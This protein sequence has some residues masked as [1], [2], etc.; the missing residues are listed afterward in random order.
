MTD[1]LFKNCLWNGDASIGA[2][3][4][5]L[6]AYTEILSLMAILLD[7]PSLLCA[8]LR[9]RVSGLAFVGFDGRGSRLVVGY[10]FSP[11]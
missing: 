9:F 1:L 11:Q 4:F 8:L 5:I 10:K 7:T 6:S 3:A 2:L